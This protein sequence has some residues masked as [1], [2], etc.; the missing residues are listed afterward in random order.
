MAVVALTDLSVNAL[1]PTEK[2]IKY[3][4]KTLPAFGV[5]V[6]TRRKTFVVMIGVERKLISL[7]HYPELSLSEARKKAKKVLAGVTVENGE[8]LSFADARA[9]FIEQHTGR[10]G[11]KRELQR[12]LTKHASGIE[13]KH[14][15]AVTT[16]HLDGIIATLRDRPSECLHFWRA[17]RTF[18]RWCVRRRFIT[19]SPLTDEPPAK[20][21][22]GDRVLTDSE[23]KA[24]WKATED[25]SV[26]SRI[27]RL[28]LITAQ[29][30]T[31]ISALRKDWLTTPMALAELP[32]HD[33]LLFPGSATRT[34][35]RLS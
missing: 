32:Q 16:D 19:R 27:V 2:Q 23:I 7:G 22:I 18:F 15:N 34:P 30:R 5:R 26:F 13:R 12:L 17:A 35:C 1:K 20:E 24:I 9:Q 10:P 31:P 28:L 25:R 33:G 6:G 21:K 4:D 11:T 8:G 29:R 3:F 14:L